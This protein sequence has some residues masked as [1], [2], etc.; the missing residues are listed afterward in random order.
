[1]NPAE[2]DTVE[3]LA[4]IAVAFLELD[5]EA[6]RCSILHGDERQSRPAIQCFSGFRLDEL[7]LLDW[8]Q[9]NWEPQL[10]QPQ[11][12]IA[13][14][15]ADFRGRFGLLVGLHSSQQKYLG[16]LHAD[17]K[18]DFDDHHRASLQE[19]ARRYSQHLECLM[20]AEEEVVAAPEPATPPPQPLET[21][22]D[23]REFAWMDFS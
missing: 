12:L 23:L 5:L 21:P 16:L 6:E 3:E 22:V 18:R 7:D 14:Q 8:L 20:Q 10:R 9:W 1:M 17:R 11:S 19:F 15:P 4:E 2:A 13:P